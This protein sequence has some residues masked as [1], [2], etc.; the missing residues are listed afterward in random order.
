MKGAFRGLVVAAV[1]AGALAIAGTAGAGGG[2]IQLSGLQTPI[3]ADSYVMS[4][5]LVGLWYTTS[6]ILDGFQPSGT[7]QGHGTELYVGCIDSDHDGFCEP[8]EPDGTLD[9]AF[10]FSGKYDTVTFAE[11]HG[12]CHHEITGGTGDFEHASGVLEFKDDPVTGCADYKG[13]IAF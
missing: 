5:D 7:L 10:N 6:F 8:G 12:R 13:H 4:G 2:N 1:A 9:F 11:I 3:S